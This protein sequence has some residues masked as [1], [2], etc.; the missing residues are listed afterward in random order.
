MI[1]KADHILK[2]VCHLLVTAFVEREPLGGSHFVS[3]AN[4]PHSRVY[5]FS[6]SSTNGVSNASLLEA[7][8]QS[9]VYHLLNIFHLT[10]HSPVSV[11]V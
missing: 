11:L 8:K 7:R 3:P 2:Y 5:S 6:V 10:L 4:T 1:F 9:Y